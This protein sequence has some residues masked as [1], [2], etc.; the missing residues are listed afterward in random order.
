M[1]ATRSALPVQDRLVALRASLGIEDSTNA[2]TALPHG[3]TASRNQLQSGLP[4]GGSRDGFTLDGIRDLLHLLLHSLDQLAVA[5]IKVARQE[6]AGPHTAVA[7][8][9]VYELEAARFTVRTL[10]EELEAWT[11]AQITTSQAHVASA[12]PRGDAAPV[13]GT[14]TEQIQRVEAGTVPEA[15]RQATAEQGIQTEVVQQPVRVAQAAQT[16]ASASVGLGTELEQQHARADKWKSRCKQAEEDATAAQAAAMAAVTLSHVREAALESRTAEETSARVLQ[17]TDPAAAT[18]LEQDSTVHESKLTD[19]HAHPACAEQLRAAVSVSDSLAAVNADL[20]TA[21]AAQLSAAEAERRSLEDQIAAAQAGRLTAADEAKLLTGRLEASQ[22]QHATLEAALHAEKDQAAA[23]EAGL[24][25]ERNRVAALEEGLRNERAKLDRARIAVLNTV[26][27]LK[28]AAEGN[29]RQAQ[30]EALQQRLS[31][32]ETALRE[33][34]EKLTQRREQA[35]SLRERHA[36]AM[37]ALRQKADTAEA[38][39]SELRMQLVEAVTCQEMRQQQ[40]DAAGTEISQMQALFEEAEQRHKHTQQELGIA[41]D[42]LAAT[43]SAAACAAAP[44]GASN[45]AASVPDRAAVMELAQHAERAVGDL[46]RRCSALE[47]TLRLVESDRDRA[48]SQVSELHET[49]WH[50]QEESQTARASEAAAFAACEAMQLSIQQLRRQH[51][52][53]CL[54]LGERHAAEMRGLEAAMVD[55]RAALKQQD[56]EDAADA[57]AGAQAA[58]DA[59]RTEELAATRQQ[60]GAELAACRAQHD[61]QV[62]VFTAKLAAAEAACASVH[63]HFGRYQAQK[64]H[65]VAALE[66]RLRDAMK[67]P[68]A[69]PPPA[70][71]SRMLAAHKAPAGQA[72]RSAKA[73]CGKY[74]RAAKPPRRAPARPA[75]AQKENGSLPQTSPTQP[76]SIDDPAGFI[77]AVMQSE[78]TVAAARE[79]SLERTQREAAEAALTQATTAA[80]A[81]REQVKAV[82]R[83]LAACQA[84]AAQAEAVAAMVRG[85]ESSAR[86]EC[87]QLQVRWPHCHPALTNGSASSLLLKFIDGQLRVLCL[88]LCMCS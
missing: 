58:A 60:H 77:A 6:P 38:G 8:A 15:L 35:R 61:A 11:A 62:E 27:A 73:V 59:A 70:K 34:H 63:V 80:D 21:I 7:P 54:A 42:A 39:T 81:L 43:A 41:T 82:R 26:D 18:S 68:R 24:Q 13:E 25:A 19:S 29:T 36:E 71:I 46:A 65:E 22:E 49:A 23:L 72:R 10:L 57:L 85:Q 4:A 69:P 28:K 53:E 67:Q 52:L 45:C 1:L 50:A 55:S 86:Q 12:H 40:Q 66:E 44:D 78:A 3:S 79:V 30:L 76:S 48:Q 88:S 20:R 5:H 47:A 87:Q 16:D 14:Q 75:N 32:L 83:D 9:A 17:A 2:D 31:T 74:S 64:A 37:A 33:A 51:E 84:R 56:A